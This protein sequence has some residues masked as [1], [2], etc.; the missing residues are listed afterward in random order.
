MELACSELSAANKHPTFLSHYIAPGA[1]TSSSSSSAS[2]PRL[3]SQLSEVDPMS[4]PL[5][6]SAR[7][8]VREGQRSSCMHR[9]K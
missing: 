8:A 5:Y 4:T 9:G 3:N 1:V 7:E 6:C 2:R